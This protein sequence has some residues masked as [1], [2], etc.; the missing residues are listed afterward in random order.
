MITNAQRTRFV[1][2][3]FGVLVL[4]VCPLALGAK[5]L[6]YMINNAP[7]ANVVMVLDCSAFLLGL[8]VVSFLPSC[9]R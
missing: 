6:I 3:L 4:V 5:I 7:D 2:N 9:N 8:T 1:L